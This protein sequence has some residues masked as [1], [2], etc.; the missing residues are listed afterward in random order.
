MGLDGLLLSR[1]LA[2]PQPPGLWW[3]EH[4]D[5]RGAEMENE[6]MATRQT[7]KQAK[8]KAAAKIDAGVINKPVHNGEREAER[9]NPRARSRSAATPSDRARATVTSDGAVVHDKSEPTGSRSK[10]TAGRADV[11]AGRVSGA[12]QPPASTKRAKLIAMFERPDGASVAEIGQ[13]L[14]WLPHT[15]RAAITGLRQAGRA[16][17]RSKDAD[18]P[19]V[20]RFGPVEPASHR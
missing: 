12:N 18:D 11:G 15:V 16:V 14:G 13:R 19:S 3:C 7:S 1:R 5:R 10:P 6:V 9:R 20:Y 2:W 8:T 4:R 17:M